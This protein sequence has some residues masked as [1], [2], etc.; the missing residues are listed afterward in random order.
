MDCTQLT[1]K[2]EGGLD[3]I[4]HVILG[5]L[6]SFVLVGIVGVALNVEVHLVMQVLEFSFE[7]RQSSNFL[8]EVFVW[9][10]VLALKLEFIFLDL[11]D[12]FLLVPDLLGFGAQE[13]VVAFSHCSTGASSWLLL[14][15]RLGVLLLL[16]AHLN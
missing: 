10:K 6:G 16:D 13:Q 14:S 15:I 12:L 3:V 8:E 4:V 1:H 5:D 9:L 7:V 11:I 2:S